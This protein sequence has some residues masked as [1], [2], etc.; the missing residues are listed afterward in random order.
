VQVARRGNRRAAH[1]FSQV[2]AGSQDQSP[3]TSRLPFV[4]RRGPFLQARN[5]GARRHRTAFF[6]RVLM[7]ITSGSF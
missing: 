2:F 6:S 3:G 1:V 5:A 4:F 7:S